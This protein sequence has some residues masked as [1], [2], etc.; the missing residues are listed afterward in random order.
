MRLRTFAF[1]LP[2][3]LIAPFSLVPNMPL[4]NHLPLYTNDKDMHTKNKHPPVF[5]FLTK[6]LQDTVYTCLYM[7]RT[8]SNVF[9]MGLW[10]KWNDLREQRCQAYIEDV[11]EPGVKSNFAPVQMCRVQ[12]TAGPLD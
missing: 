3:A 1:L 4:T 5:K 8:G 9:V 6:L 7:Q 10:S 11:G 12:P 2:V